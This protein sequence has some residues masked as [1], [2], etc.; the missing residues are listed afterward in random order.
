M[1]IGSVLTGLNN[2]W[3]KQI[4]FREEER[5]I[6]EE[7]QFRTDQD[8]KSW[9][10]Q[11]ENQ[12]L[13]WDR[14]DTEKRR[15][16]DL[17]SQQLLAAY[18]Q[19]PGFSKFKPAQIASFAKAGKT[20][21]DAL[22]KTVNKYIEAGGDLESL[23][24][25]NYTNSGGTTDSLIS[26]IDNSS[27]LF[28]QKSLMNAYKKNNEKPMSVGLHI[29]SLQNG[30]LESIAGGSAETDK[31]V[32]DMQTELNKWLELDK[33]MS[34]QKDVNETTTLAKTNLDNTF[35]KAYGHAL[36][37]LGREFTVKE[38][39]VFVKSEDTLTQFPPLANFIAS[40]QMKEQYSGYTNIADKERADIFW[41]SQEKTAISGL[42]EFSQSVHT[43]T[44]NN[45]S[46]S[47][48]LYESFKNADDFKVYKNNGNWKPGTV[49]H[50]QDSNRILMM[51]QQGIQHGS[52]KQPFINFGVYSIN[53]DI[54]E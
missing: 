23:I 39:R 41:K 16:Q 20:G 46:D 43:Q 19:L 18:G 11:L 24:N 42:K 31:V 21:Y 15:I 38:N 54:L 52:K 26:D 27:Q 2:E 17:E 47:S 36:A 48:L 50:L 32:V 40:Q 22:N 33:E 53:D 29:S 5:R 8:D 14:E 30:I 4:E 10:R 49:V 3:D 51:V 35:N 6:T 7:R 9:S 12:K 37:S 13:G 44:L 28:S 25:Y 1:I 34:N 45:S